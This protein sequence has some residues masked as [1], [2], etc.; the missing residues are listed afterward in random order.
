MRSKIICAFTL[1]LL[2][3]ATGVGASEISAR[4]LVDHLYVTSN[5]LPIQ[6]IMIELDVNRTAQTNSGSSGVLQPA[7]R[8]KV[9]FK[10]PNKLRVDTVTIAPGD[11]TDGKQAIIIRDGI[12]RWMYVSAGQYPVKK[13]PDE[14]SPTLMLP[15]NLQIYQQDLNREYVILGKESV[16]GIPADVV[17]IVNPSSPEQMVKVWIDRSRWVPL[18]LEMRRENRSS[19]EKDKPVFLRILYKEVIQLKDGRWMPFVIEFYE[20]EVLEKVAVYRAVAVNVGLQ[21]NLFEPMD[22]F[23]K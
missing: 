18:K 19:S 16:G 17:G 3:S 15:F 5:Q 2:V 4:Q 22:K 21:D 10:K 1:L 13:G 9:F 12:N 8:D 14:P 11:P 20:N 7:S 6:D 23:I